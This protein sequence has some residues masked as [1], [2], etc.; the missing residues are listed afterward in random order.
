MGGKLPQGRRWG[1]SKK[2]DCVGGRR[3]TMGGHTTAVETMQR[4]YGVS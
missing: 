4:L 3:A 2:I 1:P